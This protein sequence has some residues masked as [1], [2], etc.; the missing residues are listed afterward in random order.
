MSLIEFY[1]IAI[2]TILLTLIASFSTASLGGAIPYPYGAPFGSGYTPPYFVVS[3][4]NCGDTTLYVRDMLVNGTGNFSNHQLGDW[5]IFMHFG[6]CPTANLPTT[7]LDGQSTPCGFF[8]TGCLSTYFHR[9]QERNVIPNSKTWKQTYDNT[10]YSWGDLDGAN[11]EMGMV[12]DFRNGAKAWNI[13]TNL[14]I[15]SSTLM[16]IGVLLFF[17]GPF[18]KSQPYL[19]RVSP[20]VL[21]VLGG[22]FWCIVLG[23]TS[24][25]SQADPAAWSTAFFQ[26]CEV[27]ISKGQVF[28]YGASVIA[29]S[30]L[31]II[32]EIL[33]LNFF[34]YYPGCY[35]E[36]NEE[37]NFASA[38]TLIERIS[39]SPI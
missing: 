8:Y 19:F 9:T 16:W 30:G 24:H 33:F 3:P 31:F 39:S 11:K 32:S 25:T 34:G 12:S 35:E 7:C 2:W 15:A 13:S 27:T 6:A 21:F 5:N 26:T 22:L 29:F 1:Y 37:N 14:V 36:E 23:L 4:K 38:V 18:F 17:C 20:Q 28:W 10:P